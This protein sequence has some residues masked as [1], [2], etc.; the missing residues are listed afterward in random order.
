[1]YV[2]EIYLYESSP[3]TT[4]LSFSNGYIKNCTNEGIMLICS[5][6]NINSS[7]IENNTNYGIDIVTGQLNTINGNW[8]AN[9]GSD[10][11]TDN[12]HNNNF[13]DGGIQTQ[14]QS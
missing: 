12:S 13:Y 11:G 4:G 6:A 14:W 10:V 9:N 8:T 5:G 7:R 1:M 3:V 2:D